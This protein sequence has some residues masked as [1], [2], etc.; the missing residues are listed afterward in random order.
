MDAT[1]LNYMSSL[2]EMMLTNFGNAAEAQQGNSDSSSIFS[3]SSL[4]NIS[5]DGSFDISQI[6]MMG[7]V[8][9]LLLEKLDI[10]ANP[11]TDP[12]ENTET[13]IDPTGQFMEKDDD[14]FDIA[15]GLTNAGTTLEEADANDDGKV[16]IEEAEAV[17]GNAA[18]EADINGDGFI[19]ARELFSANWV[20]DAHLAEDGELDGNIT[21]EEEEAFQ[22]LART[23][24]DYLS[25]K[26]EDIYD[27]IPAKYL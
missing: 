23:E 4:D 27:N 11:E 16:S 19:D 7:S 1:Q 18:D 26:I 9:A 21:A 12:D 17:L 8:I 25:S 2:F 15:G 10:G 3:F 5:G 20:R 22:T 6:G 13:T 24:S 14:G